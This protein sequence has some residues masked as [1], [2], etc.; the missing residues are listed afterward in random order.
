MTIEYLVRYRPSRY[1][2]VPQVSSAG[3]QHSQIIDEN[4]GRPVGFVFDEKDA[5]VICFAL[6]LVRAMVE[7]DRTKQLELMRAIDKWKGA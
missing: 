2:V 7:G 6:D 4:T 3:I 1:F 5:H